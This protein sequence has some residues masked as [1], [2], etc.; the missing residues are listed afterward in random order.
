MISPKQSVSYISGF[1]FINRNKPEPKKAKDL[2]DSDS[3]E[4]EEPSPT[5]K[6][7]D[8]MVS[9]LEVLRK[10]YMGV[11]QPRYITQL[12]SRRTSVMPAP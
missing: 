3:S 5:V 10:D 6:H 1:R 11:R 12:K 7:L 8:T 4:K 9:V 2:Y